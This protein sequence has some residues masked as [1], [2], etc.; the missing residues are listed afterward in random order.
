MFIA[1]NFP[2]VDAADLIII[3]CGEARGAGVS[4]SMIIGIDAIRNTFL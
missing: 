2:D 3:G 4:K 1:N